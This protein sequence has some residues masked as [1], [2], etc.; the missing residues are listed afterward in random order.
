[1]FRVQDLGLS[2]WFASAV[3][4]RVVRSAIPVSSLGSRSATPL[5]SI[6]VRTSTP[7][8][9]LGVRGSIPLSTLGSR[10]ASPPLEAA[11]VRRMKLVRGRKLRAWLR[12]LAASAQPQSGLRVRGKH[13]PGGGS[14]KSRR[15][16][17]G[18]PLFPPR[19]CYVA[20]TTVLLC[21]SHQTPVERIWHI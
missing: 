16:I 21:P 17:R 12:G 14:P 15:M 7:L 2:K 4:G 10:R 8:S 19:Y 6:G 11:G 1:M 3:P 9:S 5:S 13:T 20:A 18:K